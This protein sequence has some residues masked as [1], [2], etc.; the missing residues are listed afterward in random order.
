MATVQVPS[1]QQENFTSPTEQRFV[2]RAVD[3]ATYRAVANALGE[4]HV[5]LAYDGENLE[6]MTVSRLHEWLSWL[7]GR[8]LV[9]L[10]EKLGW[11]I[12]SAG[13]TTLDREDVNRALEP[14][15]SFYITNEAKM[16]QR[17]EIDLQI[18][19]PPD[20][21]VEIDVSRSS[22]NRLEIYAKLRIPE[23]WRCDG[24]QL[25]V[26]LLNERGEYDKSPTSRLF[27]MI[28][29]AEIVVFLQRR[30]EMDENSLVKAF[31]A[32]VREQVAKGS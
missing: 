24:E 20:L 31:R 28:P 27:P 10:T 12:S 23:V 2:L 7:I 4:R 5:R 14:D 11:P 1:K 9:V 19:P 21:A 15:E 22:L 26:Y 18:D 16:R 8:F 32:W 25:V 30:G 29:V 13:S 6:F 17:D 3:W